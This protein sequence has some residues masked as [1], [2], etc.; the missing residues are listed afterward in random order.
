MGALP[1]PDAPWDG[2]EFKLT[3]GRKQI[4]ELGVWH[5]DGGGAQRGKGK[6]E[7]D[8]GATP[9]DQTPAAQ[10]GGPTPWTGRR[11]DAVRS[12]S[13]T[14]AESTP[15]DGD[16][17][18]E[19]LSDHRPGEA[20][21]DIPE[22]WQL[23]RARDQERIAAIQAGDLAAYDELFREYRGLA[24]AV[25]MDVLHDLADA[26]DVVAD[27]FTDLLGAISRGTGP[28]GSFGAY[29]KTTVRHAAYKSSAGTRRQIPTD[30]M[31]RLDRMQLSDNPVDE[32]SE[33]SAV[34]R[35]F[36][37]LPEELRTVLWLTEV[38]GLSPAE[39]AE[40][41]GSTPSRVRELAARARTELSATFVA[42][43]PQHGPLVTALAVLATDGAELTAALA[44]GGEVLAMMDDDLAADVAVIRTAGRERLGVLGQLVDR[45]RPGPRESFLR[46]FAGQP[47]ADIAAAMAHR[48]SYIE[49]QIRKVVRELSMSLSQP[50][51]PEL[52]F[53]GPNSTDEAILMLIE[54]VWAHDRDLVE[55]LGSPENER[56]Y[57]EPY[58]AQGHT[59]TE[60]A[61]AL[62]RKPKWV[63]RRL[64]RSAQRL[65]W[66]LSPEVLERY[67]SGGP[68]R[69]AT[70]A[71]V[72]RETGV[73]VVTVKRVLNG[74][75]GA[76]PETMEQIRAAAHRLGFRRERSGIVADGGEQ[77]SNSPVPV[78]R[79]NT[80]RGPYL[81][82]GMALQTVRAAPVIELK[83]LIPFLSEGD[84]D[85]ARL[86]FLEGLSIPAT[87]E[88]L[89]R[90]AASIQQR[91]HDIADLLA[92]IL[93]S[94][95][96]ELLLIEAVH[97]HDPAISAA[98]FSRLTPVQQQYADQYLVQGL[99][100]AE[101]ATARGIRQDTVNKL[102]RRI[103]HVLVRELPPRL[104]RQYMSAGPL[105]RVTLA[106]IAGRAGVSEVTA[107]RVLSG[108]TADP[109][110]A[111][112]IQEE[113]D[114]LGWT[115]RRPGVV[116]DS[117][118]GKSPV[119]AVGEG[120]VG[121]PRRGRAHRIIQGADPEVLAACISQLPREYQAGGG[122][123]FSHELTV[124]E[125]SRALGL[126]PARVSTLLQIAAPRL[127]TLLSTGAL[128]TDGSALFLIEAIAAHDPDVLSPGYAQL[129][130]TEWEYADLYLVQ[131]ISQSDVA[132]ATG[133]SQNTIKGAL[134]RIAHVLAGELAPELVRRLLS[135]G[136]FR[137][138]KL[139]DVAGLA[140][141]SKAT[142]DR[143]LNDRGGSNPE[144]VEKVWAAAA[145]LAW[146]QQR[147]GIVVET[148]TGVEP[149]SMLPW[150]D[151]TENTGA[152]APDN[153]DALVEQAAEAARLG[154][155]TEAQVVDETDDDDDSDGDAT[156]PQRD[157]EPPPNG[158]TGG[159]V[160]L[161][162]PTADQP[163]TPS[164]RESD[165]HAST[166]TG[167]PKAQRATFI[168]YGNVGDPWDGGEVKLGL[169]RN[170]QVP[171][172]G[173]FP[174]DG[175]GAARRRRPEDAPGA[176]GRADVPPAAEST[177]TADGE[178]RT[179][180]EDTSHALPAGA[181]NS[182]PTALQR[183]RAACHL[184]IRLRRACAFRRRTERCWPG[185]DGNS[186]S[187]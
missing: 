70:V 41:L 160:A 68:L 170:K 59:V 33:D 25:A 104:V 3:S 86:L 1:D 131:G 72:A 144:T 21:A 147:R 69:R 110:T 166:A 79:D 37:A 52:L 22:R 42:E 61:A 96:W 83:R 102:L 173:P 91:Q 117:S 181:R 186:K 120:T 155:T 141:V 45:L 49:S 34:G 76:G 103:A 129:S 97:A 43:Q 48:D 150:I 124:E 74:H 111:L 113:A 63:R 140:Q 46:W 65:A 100:T 39:A 161:Q 179:A 185:P 19:S 178:P 145:Q 139:D 169:G 18:T 11:S 182:N 121:Y 119:P 171:G 114:R 142:A 152:T 7:P 51:R 123:L 159:S 164:D 125:K 153:D 30:D 148:E 149:A 90:P 101:V 133:R 29:L 158:P 87:A 16:Q 95:N 187:N 92:A 130:Q 184:L 53:S 75:G 183:T 35:A 56:E 60:I 47:V 138:V 38:E 82:R 67:L 28:T 89:S 116:V 24:I 162:P 151:T 78:V 118:E 107:R 172:L 99:S 127:A 32:L 4:A 44:V 5:I 80:D 10:S 132:E 8:S 85:V 157:P 9:P 135:R 98:S 180:A 40:Q 174:A 50:Q 73:S 128:L 23:E 20:E 146:T 6:P 2:G 105:R 175:G 168:G 115:S 112:R 108:G 66:A 54:A 31:A 81:Q 109:K 84:Q 27:C 106:D 26:E 15:F 143:V 137:R 14:S 177:H 77:A 36:E 94:E 136:R 57:F 156:T 88:Q 134:Y 163:A 62:G 93:R 154:L 122:L 55:A 58:F 12:E 13:A 71:D 167:Q 126:S 17:P 64:H 165:G 176:A